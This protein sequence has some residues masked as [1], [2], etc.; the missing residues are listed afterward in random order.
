MRETNMTDKE[1][2][3]GIYKTTIIGSVVNIA[4]VA[5]QFV[6]GVVGNSSAMIADAVHA[7]SDLMTDIVILVFVRIAHKPKDK[8]HNYGHGKFET[9]ATLLIGIVLL[10]VGL[11]I[12]FSG[13][14]KIIS[15]IK[16]EIL[17]SPGMIAF[18]AAL[19]GIV[20]KEALYLYTIACGRKLKS[21]ATIANAWHHRSDAFSSIGTAVGIGGAILLGEKWTI[22]DPLAALIVSFFIVR[23][24]LKLMKP[25]MDELMERSLSN[26]VENEIIAIVE[27][28][29]GVSDLHN[30]HTRKLG[31]NCAI[32]FHIRIDGKTPLVAAHNTVTEIEH[33]LKER[34]GQGTHVIIHMEPTLDEK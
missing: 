15:V 32:E 8:D 17:Q 6:A 3:R 4:L 23:V 13:T 25:C 10:F 30:L 9:F 28:F 34:Y 5:F 22:L 26:G 19:A 31:N 33:R 18:Y 29:D 21:D 7:L 27:S 11:G 14:E 1:R 12:A 16:G 24:A 20:S 2:E